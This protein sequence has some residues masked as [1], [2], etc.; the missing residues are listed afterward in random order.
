MAMVELNLFRREQD[1]STTA[2]SEHAHTTGKFRSVA[3]VRPL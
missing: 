1:N 2:N 3:G